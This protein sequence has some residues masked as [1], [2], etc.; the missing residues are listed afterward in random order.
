MDSTDLS[1]S[2]GEPPTRGVQRFIARPDGEVN[3]SDRAPPLV[4][5]SRKLH[6]LLSKFRDEN[7]Y[8]PVELV[9]CVV[10]VTLRNGNG[11]VRTCTEVS[12][13]RACSVG[14]LGLAG[15]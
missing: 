3:F 12:A 11:P 7:G 6:E 8:D 10:K 5:C 14:P 2:K 9:A 13:R 1:C 15:R 4:R